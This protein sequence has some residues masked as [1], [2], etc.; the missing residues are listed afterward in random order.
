MNRVGIALAGRNASL[1][2]LADVGE[3]LHQAE[4]TD[5]VGAVAVLEAADQLALEHRHQRQDGEDH[6]E[7][8]QALNDHDPGG[9]DELSVGD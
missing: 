6:A 3:R 5:P 1:E 4:G 8:D 2:Q 7:D 9:F